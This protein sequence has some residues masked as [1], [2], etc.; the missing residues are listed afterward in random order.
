M[1]AEDPFVIEVI[2]RLQNVFPTTY[3]KMF[4]GYGIFH[5]GLMFALIADN[6]LYLKSD[7]DSESQF[8][9]LNLKPFTYYKKGKPYHMH[10]HQ[11]PEAFFEDEATTQLWAKNAYSCALRHKR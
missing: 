3:R 4:G 10:Y 2:D 1:T 5:N 8:T 6:E 7:L 11:A 9:Q